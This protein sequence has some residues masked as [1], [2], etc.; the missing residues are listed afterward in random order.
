MDHSHIV[1]IL[2]MLGHLNI[3]GKKFILEPIL[4]G[5]ILS[6]KQIWVLA[7]L[8]LGYSAPEIATLLH[9]SPRTIEGHIEDLKD[10]LRCDSKAEIIRCVMTSLFRAEHP[11]NKTQ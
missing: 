5:V 9:R 2:N 6:Q 11:K 8:L 4:P 10:K 7:Y 3:T 1:P